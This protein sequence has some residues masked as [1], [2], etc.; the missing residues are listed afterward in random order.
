MDKKLYASFLEAKK[1]NK[2][3]FVVLIDPDNVRLNKLEKVLQLSKEAQVDYFF[4][5]R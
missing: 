5:R 1:S 4:Y 3:K 2:K